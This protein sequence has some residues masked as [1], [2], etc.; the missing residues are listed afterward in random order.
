M[1]EPSMRLGKNGGTQSKC[2][3]NTA[4]GVPTRAIT[5]KRS[6]STIWV[7]TW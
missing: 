2:V 5:L 4:R 3:D 6:P 7:S 1:R